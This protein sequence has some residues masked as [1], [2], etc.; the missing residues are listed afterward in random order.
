MKL[1]RNLFSRHDT[2]LEQKI[3]QLEL[4]IKRLEKS[5]DEAKDKPIHITVENM[6]VDRAVLE[7]LTFKMDKLDIK[8]L[9]GSLNIGNNIGGHKTSKETSL[10]EEG[11]KE[12]RDSSFKPTTSGY[13]YKRK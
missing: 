7:S 12:S 5:L 2:N 13:S 1:W 10:K 6:S 9:S 11:S 8:E 4:A 3:N